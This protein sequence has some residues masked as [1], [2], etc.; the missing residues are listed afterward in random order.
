MSRLSIEIPETASSQ[1]EATI[2]V[3]GTHQEL[4]Q[5][6]GFLV[7]AVSDT[8][9]APVPMLLAMLATSMPKLQ[10]SVAEKIEF[11]VGAIKRSRGGNQ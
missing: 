7:Y 10:R 4:M 11:N 3:E 1:A 5:C 8:I 9:K 2:H 6:L